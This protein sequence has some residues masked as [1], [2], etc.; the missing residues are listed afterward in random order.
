MN[1]LSF[2]MKVETAHS[3]IEDLLQRSLLLKKSSI[4][5]V[6]PTSEVV[7]AWILAHTNFKEIKLLPHLAI[8]DSPDQVLHLKNTVNFFDPLRRCVIF[9]EFEESPYMGLQPPP[10]ITARRVGFLYQAQH[11]RPGDIFICTVSALLQTTMPFDVLHAHTYSL[12]SGQELHP[13]HFSDVHAFLQFLGYQSAPLVEDLGQYS[14]RGGI[15]D[16]YSPAHANP[17]RIEFFGDQIDSLRFFDP[18]SQR[19]LEDTK[20]AVLIPAKEILFLENEHDQVL[21]RFKENVSAGADKEE[22]LRSLIHK[23][24]YPGIEYLLPIFYSKKESALNHF[25]ESLCLWFLEKENLQRQSDLV[26]EQHKKNY[27]SYKEDSCGLNPE[28]LFEKFENL[29]WPDLFFS[30]DLSS[31]ENFEDDV[32]SSGTVHYPCTQLFELASI[33]SQKAFSDEWKMAFSKKIKSWKN[34]GFKIFVC[35]PH[36]SRLAQLKTFFD[37]ESFSWILSADD[38]YLWDSW[39]HSQNNKSCDL[40]LINRPLLQSVKLDEEKI[41]FL[42]EEDFFGKRLKR[43]SSDQEDF[44]NKAKLMSFAD[45]KPGDFIVH[46]KHGVGVYEGLKIMSIN[47]A[48]SEFLQLSYK[49]KDRLY[50]PVYRISQI[51]KYSVANSIANLDKLGTQG[52]EK[53]K[54]KVKSALKD[55]ASELLQLYAK[56]AEAHRIPFSLDEDEFTKFEK[57]FPYDETEDQLKAIENIVKDFKSSRPMDRLVCGDVGFGKTEIAMRA[58]FLAVQG[59]KQVAVLAPTTV[60]TFQHHETFKKRFHNW[61]VDIRVLNRFVSTKDIKKTIQDLK[62]G[63][64]DILIGTHKLLGQGVVFKD[65]GLLIIDEEQKFGVTHK[66]KIRKLKINVDTLTLSATPIPRTLNM[67][68]SGLRDLSLINTAPIDRL[69]IRTMISKFDTETIRKAILAEVQRGGQVYFVHNRIQSIYGLADEL[70]QIVPQIR[71]KVAHGQMKEDDL[72]NVMLDFFH[73]EIDVLLSTAIIESGMDISRANTMF[74]DSAHMFGLSQLYQL[75]GRVGRSKERAYCYLMIPKNLKLD[76][77]QQERL[78]I[79]QENSALG[80]GIKIAQYD[81]ELRG[82]GNLLGDDQSGFVNSVGY[83]LYM[84]LLQE[85]IHEAKGEPTKDLELDPEIN[86]KIPALIPDIYISDIRLRLSYYKAMSDIQDAND[87]AKIEDELRDQFGALPDPVINLMGLMLIRCQCK[88]LGIRDISAGLKSISLVFSDRTPITSEIAIQL[89]MRSN[90]K[91]SLT[92]DSRLNIRLNSI[93]WIQVQ[94]ELDELAKIA[95]LKF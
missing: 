50:L 33:S 5:L 44:Q 45:L 93:T 78:R 80:S 42:R 58:A 39:L 25:S 70:R 46:Q 47:G 18:Q 66:E 54:I 21:T 81:L 37:S 27:L 52:W 1:A 23:N 83:E 40:I 82:S 73:H 43:T 28:L 15:L 65:L 12:S 19:S 38:E 20:N 41:I 31:L 62:D 77:D 69:P 79:I 95:N 48:E 88:K 10:A 60:L 26:F 34:D 13:N 64:V 94:Q 84:D 56:R 86:L 22:I 7:L 30:V 29:S 68:L 57:S 14:L 76:K 32:N 74:I 61:P 85:A 4:K 24:Y 35:C 92:P 55:I 6:A 49:D 36:Q 75:R 71:M 72:E 63:K 89:A 9:P 59:R 91:Y 3:R 17:V 11:S 87:L 51:N 53:T 8:L 90:K 16:F 2:A 67:S